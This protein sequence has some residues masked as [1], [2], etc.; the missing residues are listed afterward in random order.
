M[1]NAR[2]HHSAAMIQ[3][4]AILGYKIIHLPSY[5]PDL[6]P[7][8]YVFSK[9][10]EYFGTVVLALPDVM[11]DPEAIVAECLGIITPADAFNY[12]LHCDYL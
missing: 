2:I 11:F 5:S 9:A 3:R 8:E 6:N 7:I 4:A 12:I 10:K 1:D